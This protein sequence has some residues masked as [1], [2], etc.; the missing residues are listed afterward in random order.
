MEKELRIRPA[1]DQALLVEFGAEISPGINRRVHE[2]ARKASAHKIS[3]IGEMVSSYCSVLVYFDPLLLSF[4]ETVSWV[5]EFL[6]PEPPE[7]DLP[8]KIK[9]V[10]VLYGGDFG[11]DISFIANHNQI[12]VGEVIRLHT[13]ETYLIY[14]VGF[15]PGFAAMGSV[16]LKIQA[17]RLA[18]PRTKVPAGA[19]GIGG[20]QTGIYA[21]ESPGGWQLIGQTPLILFDLQKNPPSFFQAGDY[22][23]FYAI[24]EKEFFKIARNR[25]QKSEFRNQNGKG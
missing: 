17:P 13:G 6:S 2:F 12:T 5:K 4:S 20:Q 10:P 11:P 7:A 22:A 9:E 21:V 8:S 16:P 3:G 23:R 19:V 24:D 14:V 18:S 1:G 15:S 25:I